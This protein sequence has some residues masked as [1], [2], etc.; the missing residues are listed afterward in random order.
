ME[1]IFDFEA[2]LNNT[3]SYY[4]K[5]KRNHENKKSLSQQIISNTRTVSGEFAITENQITAMSPR[6]MENFAK[7]K[8]N[9]ILNKINES[10]NKIAEAKKSAEEAKNLKSGFLGFN[11]SKKI[12]ANTDTNLLLTDA[13]ND[14]NQLLQE[15]IAFVCLSVEF[16]K[17]MAQSLSFLLVNGFK[18]SSGHIVK[19]NQDVQKQASYIIQQAESFSEQQIRSK[20]F[21]VEQ[22]KRSDYQ[23]SQIDSLEDRIKKLSPQ[24]SEYDNKITELFNA[25]KAASN[26]IQQHDETIKY[27][28]SHNSEYGHQL[29]QLLTDTKSLSQAIQRHDEKINSILLSQEY[30][31][32]TKNNTGQQGMYSSSITSE[33]AQ[34][35]KS[36]KKSPFIL[37]LLAF[38]FSLGALGLMIFKLF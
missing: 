2:E 15:I 32:S 3:E 36:V 38:I 5:V 12:N 4:D 29:E 18:D 14:Q 6:R 33:K 23:Q 21:Q 24:N 26:E 30:I 31:K 17:Y 10:V 19:L 16:S 27:I 8:A 28:A 11:A 9:V 35:N 13:L 25:L 1:K 37:S 7:E 20:Q 22:I 34:K